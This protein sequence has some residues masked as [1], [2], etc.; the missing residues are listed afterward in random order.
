MPGM[1]VAL[2]VR[3]FAAFA[4]RRL[5]PALALSVVLIIVSFFGYQQYLYAKPLLAY[6]T[7]DCAGSV[8]LEVNEAG[9]VKVATAID[10]AGHDALSQVNYINKP[11]QEVVAA[12]LRLPD[13][14]K[15]ADV[16]VAVVPVKAGPGVDTLEKKVVDGA[17][18]PVAGAEPKSV[19]SLRLD[20]ETRDS[21]KKLGISAGRAALW[22]LS[23]QGSQVEGEPV[24]P[25]ERPHEAPGKGPGP[26]EQPG[27]AP[28]PGQSGQTGQ[29]GR[30][31]DEETVL[32]A[33]KGALPQVDPKDLKDLNEHKDAKERGQYLKDITKDWVERVV[34]ELRKEKES[35]SAPPGQSKPGKDTK[36][37]TKG[38]TSMAPSGSNPPAPST[39]QGSA[40][41]FEDASGRPGSRDG[42]GNSGLQKALTDLLRRFSWGNQ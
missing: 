9:L 11:A 31:P 30:R 26:G 10:D 34:E 8:E 38:G 22:A 15:S 39:D 24:T 5:V 28:Q 17:T 2:P 41:R 29:A 3:G 23:R 7:V 42:K 20:A 40:P 14:T 36:S 37:S 4:W 13:A 33:I 18:K 6:V 25:D 1:E 27:Q 32:D 19:T 16:V 21:A 35:K 12:L